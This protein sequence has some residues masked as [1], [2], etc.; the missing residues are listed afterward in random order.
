MDLHPLAQGFADVAADYERGRP[1][2][3]AAAVDAVRDGLGLAP[4]ARIADVGAGTG[5]L[6][7]ALLVAPERFDVVAVEPFAGMRDALRAALGDGVAV[8][9]GT[10]EALPLGDA[11]VDAVACADAFHWFDGARAAP[12]L[13]RAIRPGGGLALLWNTTGGE[14]AAAGHAWAAELIDLLNAARP[15]HPGFTGE[16][17]REAIDACAAFG[18]FAR[19]DITHVHRSSRAMMV[20]NVASISYVAVLPEAEHR[21]LLGRVDALLAVHGVEALDVPLRTAVWT[22]RRL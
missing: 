19:A 15:E 8:L 3:P 2:Y 9:A 22:A 7:R 6:T 14:A 18:P 5:K 17:G 21:A 20:A 4:G 11:S 12:E 10:A 1:G 13:A 16:Q